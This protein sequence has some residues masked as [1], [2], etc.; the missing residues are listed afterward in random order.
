ML[1]N[2][3]QFKTCCKTK[4]NIWL[5]N[6]LDTSSKSFYS[7]VRESYFKK[8]NHQILHFQNYKIWYLS[9]TAYICVARKSG[10]SAPD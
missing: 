8:R 5:D 10:E 1:F 2:M 6:L 9:K 3:H 4:K 7:Y